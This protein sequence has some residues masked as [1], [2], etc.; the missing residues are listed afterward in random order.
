MLK[1][2][3]SKRKVN[4]IGLFNCYFCKPKKKKY[5]YINKSKLVK[6]Y[7]NKVRRLTELQDLSVIK[8]I[9]LRHIES[10]H[11]DH[12]IPITICFEKGITISYAASKN[13]LQII[14]KNENFIKGN[15]R[16]Y[17]VIDKCKHIKS[18]LSMFGN[19]CNIKQLKTI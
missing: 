7:K 14:S 4:R 15:K 16:A 2:D 8:D 9:S 3:Y 10:Y 12:I 17:S 5:K 13:N 11:L 1:L 6:N 19:L 18:D